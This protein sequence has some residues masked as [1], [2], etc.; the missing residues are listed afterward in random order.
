MAPVSVRLQ[1]PNR[2]SDPFSTRVRAD[3]PVFERRVGGRPIA[4]FDGPGGSQVPRQVA[5]AVRDYLL[6][7]NANAHGYFVTSE[8]TDAN[9]GLI[10]TSSPIGKGLL[11]KQ[12]GDEVKIPIPGGSRTM[13]ILKLTTI[14][15]SANDR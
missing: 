4:F 12:V 1:H 15:D 10:S 8:E 3:F 7:H 5:D 2:M 14:H 11:G 6:M 9:N 13:E